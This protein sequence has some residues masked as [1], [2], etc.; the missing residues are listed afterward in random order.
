M[1]IT[2]SKTPPSPTTL[3]AMSPPIIPPESTAALLGLKVAAQT[4]SEKAS[5]LTWMIRSCEAP[6]V[7]PAPMP[8]TEDDCLE[9]AAEVIG[10]DAWES[11][12]GTR[13]ID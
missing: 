11:T 3:A 13:C 6:D 7:P 8:R 5:F 2:P 9:R 12:S 10:G 4:A 1:M